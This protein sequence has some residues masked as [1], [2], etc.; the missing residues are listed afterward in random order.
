ME[1]NQKIGRT[2][3]KNLRRLLS[4]KN[5]SQ[6][7][8]AD[9]IGVSPAAV[10]Q[11]CSGK[12]VP[13]MNKID[14]ICKFLGVERSDL[15]EDSSPFGRL[16]QS[17]RLPVL[18]AIAGGTPIEAY[19][20]VEA[21]EWADVPASSASQ[22]YPLI[23]LRVSGDSM[24]PLICDGDVAIVKITYEWTNGAVMAVYVNGHNAT[25]KRVR[26]DH[27]GILTLQPFNPSHEPKAYTPEEQERLP[28]RP[29]GL[30]VE[31]RKKWNQFKN[32]V[33]A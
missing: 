30:L 12:V 26:I 33:H 5:I 3:G 10:S 25:L 13:R 20:D 27:N 6:L 21:D 18:G 15:L 4:L 16:S 8:L 31:T 22:N 19:E 11:W 1:S 17:F 2:F 14:A 24:E 23:A 28:V 7:D 29:L 32:L 9:A